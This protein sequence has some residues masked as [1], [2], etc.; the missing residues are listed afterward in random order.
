MS[1]GSNAA[2]LWFIAGTIPF[3]VAGGAHALLTLVDT[4][5]PTYFAPVERSLGAELEGTGIRFRLLVPGGDHSRPS[6]WRAWLGFN[7]S[8]GLGVFAFGLL[9]LV[10][11]VA[12]P[13]LLERVEAIALVAA[14]VSATYLVLALRFWFWVPVLITGTS[15]ACFAIA[16][17]LV[18]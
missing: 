17:L 8:H 15:T 12:E 5:R 10:I 13:G 6:M 11:A 4:I 16:A 18:L 7:I 3:L 14:L 2:Q 9:A 1:N